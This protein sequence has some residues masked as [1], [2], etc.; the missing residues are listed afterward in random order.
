MGIIRKEGFNFGFEPSTC[1]SCP[2]YCCHGASGNIWVNHEDILKMCRFLQTNPID[3]I[4]QYLNRINNR[5][6]IKERGVGMHDLEYFFFDH[7]QKC[8]SI[9]KA[10]PRQY[11]TFPFWEYFKRHKDNLIKECPGIR[12][13]K[14][15]L[16]Y[17][18]FTGRNR[19]HV[20]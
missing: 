13:Q 20:S 12:P 17:V 9:Y 2:G 7:R 16:P 6:S 14:K 8:C 18:F 15:S 1:E 10:R 5:F 19:N 4:L 3:F 11:R